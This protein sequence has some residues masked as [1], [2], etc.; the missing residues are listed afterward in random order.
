MELT[1]F[2]MTIAE[3]RKYAQPARRSEYLPEALVDELQYFGVDPY[4]VELT[5][6]RLTET[7]LFSYNFQSDEVARA[8]IYSFDGTEFML[9]EKY[10]DRTSW[11][12]QVLNAD[13]FRNFVRYMNQLVL[14]QKLSEM[15][16]SVKTDEFELGGMAR[17][18][19]HYILHSTDGQSVGVHILSPKWG[20][21]RWMFQECNALIGDE[22]VEFVRWV[23]DRPSWRIREGEADVVLRFP[24][25]SER[26][27][28]GWQVRFIL[29]K[30]GE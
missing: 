30:T 15:S 17:V 18:F 11:D 25:G 23:D 5:D 19:N 22:P 14:E 12:A 24:D 3:A 10:G 28:A 4:G 6:G 13:V 20:S 7:V 29:N 21:F 26:A 2:N 9:A 16:V 8:E 27:V 1:K